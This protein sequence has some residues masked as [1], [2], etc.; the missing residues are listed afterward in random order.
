MRSCRSTHGTR[1]WSGPRRLPAS[2]RRRAR[3]ASRKI[4]G[5]AV[6]GGDSGR[7]SDMVV[8]GRRRAV[9][10]PLGGRHDADASA[11]G[12]GLPAAPSRGGRHRGRHPLRG[13]GRRS[14]EAFAAPIPAQVWADLRGGASSTNAHRWTDQADPLAPGLSFRAF[15]SIA[16]SSAAQSALN[17]PAPWRCRRSARASTS[18]PASATAEMV[19]SAAA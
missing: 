4:T 13:G 17:A 12:D 11:G 1:T 3:P 14:A 5:T 8:A 15:S 2:A 16:V 7:D 10:R 18:T 6:S 19:R 9:P